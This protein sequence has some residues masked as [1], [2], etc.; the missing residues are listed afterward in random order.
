MVDSQKTLIEFKNTGDFLTM[1]SHYG[2]TDLPWLF[3]RPDLVLEIVGKEKK[4]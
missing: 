2:I 1:S 4:Q 3:L